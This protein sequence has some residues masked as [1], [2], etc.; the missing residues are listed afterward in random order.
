[1]RVISIRGGYIDVTFPIAK[2]GRELKLEAVGRFA[3]DATSDLP[4]T[5]TA[6]NLQ[7]SLAKYKLV[8]MNRR[9]VIDEELSLDRLGLRDRGEWGLCGIG[10]GWVVI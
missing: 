9:D 1:M 3:V 5:S 10:I 2:T 8:T 4:P 7:S 6:T